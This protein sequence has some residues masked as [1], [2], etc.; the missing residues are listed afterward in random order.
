[1]NDNRLGLLNL[2]PT[3][4]TDFADSRSEMQPILCL[5]CNFSIMRWTGLILGELEALL[6]SDLILT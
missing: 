6:F 4:C 2:H 3:I 5:Q 1:M